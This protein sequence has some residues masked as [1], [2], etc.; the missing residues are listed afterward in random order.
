MKIAI[1]I[2]VV[3]II[4]II[5]SSLVGSF[6]FSKKIDNE[7]RE[8][9]SSVSYR[10]SHII[11]EEDLINLPQPIQKWL[12]LSGVIGK[13]E[14]KLA[15]VKQKVLMKLKPEQK[16]WYS[17][18][19]MQYIRAEE[20][21]FIWTLDMKM[22]PFINIKGRDKSLEGRGEM[23]IKLNSLINVANE[24]GGNIDEGAMQR[25]LAEIVWLPSMALSRLIKWEEIDSL[26]AKAT[27]NY[28]GREVSGNFYFN[29][30]GD[31]TG[32]K[33][34]RY[35]DNTPSAKRYLWEIGVKEYKTFEGIRVPSKLGVKW[36]ID[37]IDWTWLD[38]EVEEIKYNANAIKQKETR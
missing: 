38:L 31:F 17:A 7:T 26:S 27:L 19:A 8:I 28:R 4:I 14:I 34:M 23:L 1:L 3:I 20:P 32:F 29:N 18:K 35:K 37:K 30:E 9:I 25:Y 15:Y 5:L 36:V 24:K 12:R 2:I 22:M 10:E 13:E 33:T 16:E 11:N 21:A 6:I